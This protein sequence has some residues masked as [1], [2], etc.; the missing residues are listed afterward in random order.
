MIWNFL[1]R[2]LGTA[3]ETADRDRIHGVLA[4]LK[5]KSDEM[6][7]VASM[8][9]E[10]FRSKW[11]RERELNFFTSL[12]GP[13]ST[14]PRDGARLV[15][16]DDSMFIA[17]ILQRSKGAKQIIEAMDHSGTWRY[18]PDV[19]GS[20][21]SVKA[22][23]MTIASR[24]N[25][26]TVRSRFKETF[27]LFRSGLS[28]RETADH[29]FFIGGKLVRAS[30][31]SGDKTLWK[32]G[33]RCE[34]PFTEQ[35]DSLVDQLHEVVFFDWLPELTNQAP[36]LNRDQVY[37]PLDG[38]VVPIRA[39]VKTPSFSWEMMCGS[40]WALYLCPKCLGTF[41]RWMWKMN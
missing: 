41:D 35:E 5:L 14:S 3:E 17:S 10:A 21:E 40:E 22:R 34:R 1:F 8:E 31:S 25:R 32:L 39:A 7:Q 20:A 18:F 27:L 23:G 26:S 19:A 36:P 16:S 30:D 33:A 4:A 28:S 12:P 37:C 13:E 2:F 29:D 24:L 38:P 6:A 11:G 9:R 15:K